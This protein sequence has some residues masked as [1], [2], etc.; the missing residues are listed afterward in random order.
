MSVRI[1]LYALDLARF[2][3]HLKKP[4]V[5]LLRDY[6]R[7]GKQEE[8]GLCIFEEGMAQGIRCYYARPGRIFVWDTTR[9][10]GDQVLNHDLREEELGGIAY[11][12]RS[13]GDHLKSSDVSQLRNV[14]SAFSE[15]DEPSFSNALLRGYKHGPPGALVQI[16]RRI[17]GSDHPRTMRLLS[18]F[19]KVYRSLATDDPIK[20]RIYELSEFEFPLKPR[21]DCDVWL[22]VWEEEEAWFVVETLDLLRQE[23]VSRA[24]NLYRETMS[25]GEEAEAYFREMVEG[26]LK[27]RNVQFKSLK[28]VGFVKC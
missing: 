17:F 13:L 14:C 28:V 3:E 25:L 23:E 26:L 15:W 27:L 1:S 20:G 24:Q 6:A 9:R 19:Q 7:K 2:E 4:L 22:S 12:R 21:E 18:L 10:T 16:A 8:P 5:D 11:L